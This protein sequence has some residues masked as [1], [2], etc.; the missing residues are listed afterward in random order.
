MRNIFLILPFISLLTGCLGGQKP[1]ADK[2]TQV[3]DSGQ[4]NS[5]LEHATN[6]KNIHCLEDE[7]T[8]SSKSKTYFHDGYAKIS[9]NH[10]G[11]ETSYSWDDGWNK[12][13]G[14]TL[15]EKFPDLI[16]DDFKLHDGELI[17]M[18]CG[19]F[20]VAS[21]EDK[22]RFWALFLASLARVQSGFDPSFKEGQ[23][24]GIMGL[25]PSVVGAL[26][27]ECKGKDEIDFLEPSY[28]FACALE[29]LKSQHNKTGSLFSGSA[30]PTN[31]F[32]SLTGPAKFEFIK[33]F[34]SHA[35]SQ[36]SFCSSGIDAPQELTE[37]NTVGEKSTAKCSVEGQN[38]IY[39]SLDRKSAAGKDEDAENKGGQKGGSKD[40]T[41]DTQILEN[42][43]ISK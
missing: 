29:A 1:L 12:M 18:G 36:F 13:I 3:P 20:S 27:G 15:D 42:S 33:F 14:D 31:P 32:K 25:D 8:E 34:K 17:Q 35:S 4:V 6:P 40:A 2:R 9:T 10:V 30:S 41:A 22:K 24:S 28:S 19:G 37:S 38:K 43:S 21:K 23:N 16:S 26:G 11:R 5:Y 7:K 39:E